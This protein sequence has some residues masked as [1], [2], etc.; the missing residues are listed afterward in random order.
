VRTGQA[1][2]L[3]YLPKPE[4]VIMLDY[5]EGLLTGKNIQDVWGLHCEKIGTYGFDRLIYAYSSFI[6]ETSYGPLEDALILSNHDPD[7]FHTFTHGGLYKDA[8]LT[9]WASRND[10]AISWGVTRQNAGKL[11]ERQRAVIAYNR[12]MDVTAGYTIGFAHASPRAHGVM[13]LTARRGLSQDDVD[14]IWREHGREIEVLCRIAHM[15]FV[16][17]PRV[18]DRPSLTKRQREVLEWIGD[19]KNNQDIAVI[20]GVTPATVEKHLRMARE[21]LDVET[22]AQAVLK[23]S[24][25]DQVFVP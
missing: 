15:K 21:R 6:T 11:T 25:L 10:G 7:Y 17:L 2:P 3:F 23:A 8:P 9:A 13:A 12:S 24:F 5:L 20:L 16:S 14:A 1:W 4:L 22:T 18:T 19:G